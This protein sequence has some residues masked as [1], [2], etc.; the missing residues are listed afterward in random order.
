MKRALLIFLAILAIGGV[1][2]LWW[3]LRDTPEKVLRDGMTAIVTA[4]TAKTFNLDVSWTDYRTRQTSGF[5]S[6]SQIDLKDLA[7]PRSLGVL[8]LSASDVKGQEQTGDLILEKDAIAMRP[9][10]VKAEW[11]QLA[12]ELTQDPLGDTFMLVNRDMFLSQQGYEEALARG[13]SEAIRKALSFAVPVFVAA[14]DITPGTSDGLETLAVP[15]RA[16]KNSIKPFIL[17]FITAWNSDNPTPKEIAWADSV[18]E[19]LAAGKYRIV[20]AKITREP[21][22]ISGEIPQYDAQ[23]HEIK[24]IKFTLAIGGLNQKVNIG[25]PEK[26]KDV[27][28]QTV[29]KQKLQALPQAKLKPLPTGTS[30]VDG[31]KAGQVSTSTPKLIN[32]RET[33]LFNKY[34][35]DMQRKKR[36]Y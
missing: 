16:D 21:V 25:I 5:S 24:H 14:G 36:Q 19:M 13:A 1:L 11:R 9:R 23:G 35:E 8:R 30:T 17:S 28:N 12:Q 29:A 10:S 32:E 26:A 2:A 7:K 15:F 4:K 31:A 33:D 34:Y 22:E 6:Y 20:I 18:T 3:Y 27:T